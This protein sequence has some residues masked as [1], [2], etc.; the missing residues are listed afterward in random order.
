ME[1]QFNPS[2][3]YL[4]CHWD[5]VFCTH[6]ESE[7]W[8]EQK[9]GSQNEEPGVHCEAIEHILSQVFNYMARY[10]SWHLWRLSCKPDG[11][12]SGTVL[13]NLW[14]ICSSD[15]VHFHLRS[16]KSHVLYSCCSSDW[17]KWKSFFLCPDTSLILSCSHIFAS[18]QSWCCFPLYSQEGVQAN[19][20][21]RRG[22]WLLN[23]AIIQQV[24]LYINERRQWQF[25]P[26]FL[27]F[28][29]FKPL[30]E[31]LLGTYLSN[32]HFL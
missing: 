11:G 30:P 27:S 32:G 14:L 2:V 13:S 5:V 29:S 6:A 17:W 1:R 9:S 16:C 7:G 21:E 15:L 18:I 23:V 12:E 31:Q 25:I 10:I 3:L 22:G 26:V 20:Y 8:A 4:L 19:S 24:S 28:H